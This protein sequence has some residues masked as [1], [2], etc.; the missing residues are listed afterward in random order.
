MKSI[1]SALTVLSLI[2]VTTITAI[3][4]AGAQSVETSVIRINSTIQTWN[5]A[6]PWDKSAPGKRRA[7]G[8]L[9]SGNRVLTT[10]EMAA[11]VTYIELESADSTRTIPAKVAAIDYETNLAL[12]VP[13]NGD[14]EGFFKGLQP[15][16]LGSPAK[17]GDKVDVW[18]LENN[19]MPLVTHATIQSVD[20]L[21]SF[22]PGH[23]F[24]TYLAKGSMQS[25][26]SS[27][28]LPV[29]RDNK[30]LGLLT[31]YNAKDQIIDVM[32][33]EIISAF[34]ADAKDGKF[35]GVPSLGIGVSSTVDP[36]FRK[37]LKLPD[38]VGGL[39]ITRVRKKSAADEAGLKKG[40]VIVS[41]GEHQIGRR[42][43]Y[44]H[45][46]YGRIFWSNLVRGNHKVGDPITL[47]VLREGKEKTIKATLARTSKRLVPQHTFDQAPNYLVKGG[48]IFQELSSTYLSA[49][50]K[51]W[52]ST[53]PLNLLDVLSS[54][55][56]YQ[57]GR[58]TLVF[59][60]A[61]IP[62]PATTGYE[63]INNQIISKINGQPIAD[64]STLIK[65]FQQPGADGLHTIEFLNS[66][67]KT[68]YLDATA[69][70][71]IDAQLLKRGIPALSRESRASL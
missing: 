33:P 11:N 37:W 27:F 44:S 48:F 25:A 13:D 60:S 59:L 57:E 58:N 19:G 12:L 18:Q 32:A 61:T 54:P 45:P 49:F 24:L 7:L 40:D 4:P 35:T 20:V 26:S 47:T 55:E 14:T 10:A 69:A 6:Q 23:F 43:Y 15:L 9:L 52:Q 64:I 8:A 34:L 28:T 66:Q 63:R 31:S 50:G 39:Y 51:D 67:P 30:L 38:D 36:S 5:N 17:I 22:A 71:T 53:A 68:I 62:T 2:A 70:D 46:D 16:T 41:I 1:F 3:T 65:A 42:G 21:S 56:D 29:V